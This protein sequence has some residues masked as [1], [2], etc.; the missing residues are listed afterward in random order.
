MLV[1][2]Q[3]PHLHLALRTV[4]NIQSTIIHI[5][6]PSRAAESD[7][8]SALQIWNSQQFQL[9]VLQINQT[10]ESSYPKL[11]SSDLEHLQTRV[12]R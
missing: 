9:Q 1:H 2:H 5:Y 11:L 8:Y 3:T 4:Y 12:P 7:D 10:N 6:Y